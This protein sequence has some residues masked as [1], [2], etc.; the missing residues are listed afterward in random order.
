MSRTRTALVAAAVG[1]TVVLGLGLAVPAVAMTRG[2]AGGTAGGCAAMRDDDGG[3]GGAR[4]GRGMGTGMGAGMGA[5][6]MAG[7]GAGRGS[8]FSAYPSG[9]LTAAQRDGLVTM[10]QEETLALDL[11]TAFAERYDDPV[12]DRVAASET[13]HVEAVRGLLETYGLTDPTVGAEP[14]ELADPALASMY[15]D[16]LARGEA[17]VAAAYEVGRTV[18]EDDLARL[19]EAGAGVTAPDVAHVYA[20]LTTA[21]ERHLAAFDGDA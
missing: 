6:M 11:Y 16:L 1:G 15:D 20:Q 8:D 18:E 12:F 3:R 10:V 9:D 5:G 21:S 7:P 19:A 2:A 14:G 4:A 13:R 17:S